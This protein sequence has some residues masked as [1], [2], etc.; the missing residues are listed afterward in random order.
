MWT[1]PFLFNMHIYVKYVLQVIKEQRWLI[2]YAGG[3]MRN[4]CCDAENMYKYLKPMHIATYKYTA[5]QYKCK[6]KNI[7]HIREEIITSKSRAYL[8]VTLESYGAAFML[9]VWKTSV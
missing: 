9:L 3:H 7:F 1:N 8:S 4:S 5:K 2:L 6:N